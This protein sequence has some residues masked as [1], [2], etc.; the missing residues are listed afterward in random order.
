MRGK[1]MFVAGAAVGFV[2][3][4]RAGRERYEE[5]ANAARKILASPTV[6]EAGGAARSQATKLYGTGKDALSHSKLADRVR[7]TTHN[8]RANGSEPMSEDARQHMSSNSF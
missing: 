1:L 8:L 3:G 2:V 6:Q 5:M 4:T 7:A